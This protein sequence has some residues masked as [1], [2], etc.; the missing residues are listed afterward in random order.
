MLR[1][2]ERFRLPKAP[3]KPAEQGIVVGVVYIRDVATPHL[4]DLAFEV[5][6][7]VALPSCERFFLRR[8]FVYNALF[9]IQR[10]VPAACA[11][12]AAVH[13][14]LLAVEVSP[15]ERAV[16]RSHVRLQIGGLICEASDYLLRRS[17]AVDFLLKIG[18]RLD[19]EERRDHGQEE[20][21]EPNRLIDVQRLQKRFVEDEDRAERHGSMIVI[22]ARGWS[23]GQCRC[24]S[25]GCTRRLS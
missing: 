8:A 10:D 7:F 13:G 2:R 23:T 6:E 11:G 15:E 1:V 17:A 21:V 3:V 18:E 4:R 5:E 24:S 19:E 14:N 9:A 16:M 20:V 25:P 12:D 22:E